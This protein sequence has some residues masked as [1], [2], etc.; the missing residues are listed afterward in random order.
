MSKDGKWLVIGRALPRSRRRGLVTLSFLLPLFLWAAISYIP[1]LWHPE[2][3]ITGSGDSVYFSQGDNVGVETFA[4]EN[5]KLKEA[6]DTAMTGYRTNPVYFPAPHEVGR[7]LYSAFA[8]P[9]RRDSDP[10]FHQSV[11]NS[12]RVV[13][14]GFFLSSLIGVPLGILCGTY[15]F[16]SKL[17]EPFVEFFRYFPAPVFGALAV[18]VLGINTASKI[19]IIFIGTF[20]Q[21]VLVIANTTRT[22]D[23]SLV[24]AAQTLGAKPK[25]LL[26][27]VIIPAVM[28]KLYLDMRILLGWA[29]TYLIVA[30]VVGTSTGISWFINQQAKYRAFDNVYAAILVLGFIGL[31][32]DMALA[33]I[34][35]GLFAWQEGR[36]GPF[37]R[38]PHK[39]SAPPAPAPAPAPVA[40]GEGGAQ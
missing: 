13:F 9:P 2:V 26:F 30:E 40:A 11:L 10:W 21:Q 4:L 16:F 3:R 36:R 37:K 15:A 39:T 8:T 17:T 38:A 31:G 14:W 27:R 1:D 33:A 25:T 35:K 20:F 6:G 23:Y 28:P 29:W 18:A 5:R 7:A 19:A 24:E 32:T 34:G 22:V 12:I